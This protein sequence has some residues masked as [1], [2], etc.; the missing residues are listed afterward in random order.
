METGLSDPT[1]SK[2]RMGW[3]TSYA[4]CIISWAS[5]IPNKNSTTEAEYITLSTALRE[6]IPLMNLLQEVV[7]KGIDM[8]YQPPMVH[9]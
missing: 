2:S 4:G 8:K 1:T 6:Q 3:V 7:K 5:K 9:W